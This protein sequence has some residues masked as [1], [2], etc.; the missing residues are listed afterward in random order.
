VPTSISLDYATAHEPPNLESNIAKSRTRQPSEALSIASDEYH[1]SDSDI[2]TH[3]EDTSHLSSPVADD[4]S[5]ESYSQLYEARSSGSAQASRVA[6]DLWSSWTDKLSSLRE[7]SFS[8]FQPV[9]SHYPKQVGLISDSDPLG[10]PLLVF[11]SAPSLMQHIMPE[12]NAGVPRTY[13]CPLTPCRYSSEAVLLEDICRLPSHEWRACQKMRNNAVVILDA[14]EGEPSSQRATRHDQ[15]LKV[16]L[17]FPDI[18]SISLHL[19]VSHCPEE[20]KNLKLTSS[21]GCLTLDDLMLRAQ[22]PWD[23]GISKNVLQSILSQSLAYCPCTNHTSKCTKHA[24]GTFPLCLGCSR[25]F[26]WLKAKDMT[27]IVDRLHE[28]ALSHGNAFIKKWITELAHMR[29]DPSYSP[30][31]NQCSRGRRGI[32]HS[33]VRRNHPISP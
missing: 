11:T 14:H 31:H 20:S 27:V 6:K 15:R 17:G 28:T 16:F 19:V 30:R 33:P 12:D 9:G 24:V 7:H 32:R 10:K 18:Y 13:F 5:A 29:S 21:M 8:S 23:W 4:S 3:I 22:N 25:I 26:P 1:S 2:S